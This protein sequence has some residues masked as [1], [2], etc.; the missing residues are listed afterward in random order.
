MLFLNHL[1][2]SVSSVKWLQCVRNAVHRFGFRPL[3]PLSTGFP[4]LPRARSHKTCAPVQVRA[5]IRWAPL[6]NTRHSEGPMTLPT[7]EET[8]SCQARASTRSPRRS[9][10]APPIRRPVRRFSTRVGFVAPR[11]NWKCRCVH[12]RAAV[13]TPRTTPALRANLGR[14]ARAKAGRV[15]GPMAVTSVVPR[16]AAVLPS[17]PDEGEQ[18]F[19]DLVFFGRA[20]AA[21]AALVDLQCGALTSLAD[22][23]AGSAIGTTGR[24]VTGRMDRGLPQGAG[25]REGAWSGIVRVREHG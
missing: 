5:R 19:V 7:W 24:R 8:D 9:I 22:S 21:R 23:R 12:T 10:L 13:R 18:I 16:K 15:T 2:E 1:A 17:S 14:C 3:F 4:T 25:Q 6:C 11:G 20:D